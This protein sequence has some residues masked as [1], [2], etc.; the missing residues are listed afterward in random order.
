[1]AGLTGKAFA[2]VAQD[3]V[4]HSW[5]QETLLFIIT[6]AVFSP[7]CLNGF[8]DAYDDEL[9]VT[10]NSM[11]QKGLTSEGIRWAFTTLHAANWQPL[12]WLSHMFDVQL[13]GL[14]PFG[15][16][17]SSLLL[18]A[19]SV[20]LLI[21]L[22]NRL[23][24]NKPVSWFAAMLFAIHPQRV[25]SVVWVAE[26]KDVL[27]VF[28]GLAAVNSYVWFLQQISVRRYLLV[29]VLFSLSLMSKPMLVTLPLLLLLMD[30]LL[31]DR[32]RD[33]Q[34]Q[35]ILVEKLPLLLL[36][37]LITTLTITAQ[38]GGQALASAPLPGR[39]LVALCAA[40]EYLRMFFMPVG[41]S[42]HYPLDTA[43]TDLGRSCV[44]AL[45]VIAITVWLLRLND[46]K[47]ALF[48]WLWFIVTLLP[49]SGIVRF[50]GHFV[51]DRYTYFPHI[52][53]L[54]VIAVLL[55][56]FVLLCPT[57]RH[58]VSVAAVAV[59]MISTGLTL[60][61]IGYWKDGDTLY[62]RAIELNPG[63]WR[64]HS[65]LATI[66]SRKDRYGEAFMHLAR[67]Q[68]LRG[69]P[70]EALETLNSSYR[71]GGVAPQQLDAL[72]DEIMRTVR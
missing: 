14:Q 66:L 48:G 27:S 46:G 31:F 40:L 28:F 52:G 6:I 43:A 51:A 72:K 23:G 15:H 61:Q 36:S 9:Y 1:M 38:K 26:R 58:V 62:R 54:I 17:L 64:A 34:W 53:L 25:E 5:L 60:R 21:S 42:F 4:R 3:R 56:R 65:N 44:S 12:T 39:I 7:A 20:L 71:E 30:H 19:G 10:M 13:Y 29:L 55:P 47:T 69:Y 37:L 63:N 22:F 24:L 70:V 67:S 68:M 32:F 57:G 11:V 35:T 8:I 59:L 49:V 50:G 33:G 41:L 2:C 45:L 18:H 16:H